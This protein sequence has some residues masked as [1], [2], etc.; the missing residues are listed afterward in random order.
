MPRLL[1]ALL[2]A[3]ALPV[4]AQISITRA[5]FEASFGRQEV[6]HVYDPQSEVAEVAAMPDTMGLAAILAASGPDQTWDLTTLVESF[7]FFDRREAELIPSTPDPASFPG[8]DHPHF[9]AT[10]TNVIRRVGVRRDIDESADSVNVFYGRVED[11]GLYLTGAVVGDID[12]NQDA[13]PDTIVTRF[14]NAGAGPPGA[15][16]RP[17]PVTFGDTFSRMRVDSSAILLPNPPG[18]VFEQENLQETV[19]TTVDGWGTLI[20]PNGAFPA[21]R[22]RIVQNTDL[23]PLGQSP[24]DL[25]LRIYSFVTK[26]AEAVEL[27]WME[28][29]PEDDPDAVVDGF[30]WFQADPATVTAEPDAQPSVAQLAASYPNP[31]RTTTTVPFDLAE[32]GAVRISVYDVLGREVARLADGRYA[33]G[34]HEVSFDASTLPSGVYLIR[35][36]AAGFSATRKVLLQR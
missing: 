21:L 17:F 11:S 24:G 19:S 12:T 13:S 29:F 26:G 10:G 1:A 8:F 34:S 7:A 27:M 30:A 9:L 18:G 33:A 35:L 3:F 2:V 28:N 15:L 31:F 16:E 32:A 6:T 14:Y 23:P 36:D 5:D 22:L 20:T 25:N 4:Q